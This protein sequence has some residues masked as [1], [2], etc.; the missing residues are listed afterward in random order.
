M[1]RSPVGVAAIE[2]GRRYI[3]IECDPEHFAAAV[4]RLKATTVPDSHRRAA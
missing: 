4:E 3:G 1:G 2:T